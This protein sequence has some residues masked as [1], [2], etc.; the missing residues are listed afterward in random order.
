MGDLTKNDIEVYDLEIND[1]GDGISAYLETLFDVDEKFGTNV[2]DDDDSWVNFYAEYFPESGELKCVYIIDKPQNN[3]E[4][5]YI[6]SKAEKDLIVS[7]ME[8]LCQK[9][10]GCSL[11]DFLINLQEDKTIEMGGIT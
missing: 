11:A 2:N 6:P 3:E 7:M 10:E 4:Y 9:E 8:E 5:E 1:D